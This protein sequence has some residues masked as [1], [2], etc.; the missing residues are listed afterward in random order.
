M[1]NQNE[2]IVKFMD[3]NIISELHSIILLRTQR[4]P[5]DYNALVHLI[6]KW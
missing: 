5:T 3:M 4:I 6:T 1:V 2:N